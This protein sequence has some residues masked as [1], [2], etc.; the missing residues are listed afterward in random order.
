LLHGH[1]AQPPTSWPPALRAVVEDAD[2]T[3]G[4]LTRGLL[5]IH[6]FAPDVRRA[7][8]AG[9]PFAVSRLVNGLPMAAGRA[10]VWA[11][12]SEAAGHEGAFLRRGVSAAVERL[13]VGG[14]PGAR[15]CAAGG[16]TPLGRGPLDAPWRHRAPTAPHEGQRLAV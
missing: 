8:A 13:A 2:V 4:Y 14:A 7:L 6:R 5:S 12:L 15:N 11:P 10:R 9:L 16:C 3:V 1:L